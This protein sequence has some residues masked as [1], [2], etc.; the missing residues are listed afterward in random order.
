M[1]NS[2]ELGQ[3]V[4]VVGGMGNDWYLGTVVK[5]SPSG[6][7]TVTFGKGNQA[8]FTPTGNEIASGYHTRH[9]EHVDDR[10][11]PSY[12]ANV[13]KRRHIGAC[14]TVRALAESIRRLEP[15]HGRADLLAQAIGLLKQANE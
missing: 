2:F 7:L 11:T 9:L 3:Q 14:E 4:Y 5:V 13:A 8:R 1:A 6:Q 12:N 15:S 10:T